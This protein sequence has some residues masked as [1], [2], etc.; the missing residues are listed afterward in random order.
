MRLVGALV[1][2]FVEADDGRRRPDKERGVRG[3][4]LPETLAD[5]ADEADR[6]GQEGQQRH[7]EGVADRAVLHLLDRHVSCR[8]P[9]VGSISQPC[10]TAFRPL[11]RPALIS[12]AGVTRLDTQGLGKGLSGGGA[13][14]DGERLGGLGSRGVGGGEYDGN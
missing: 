4:G 11:G 1:G 12:R 7:H 8:F 2:E 3:G 13:E 5:A 10:D 9:H 14:R 6:T